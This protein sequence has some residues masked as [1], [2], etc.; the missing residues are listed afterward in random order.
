MKEFSKSKIILLVIIYNSE[1]FLLDIELAEK[2]AD[3]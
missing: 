1:V 3:K 2:L